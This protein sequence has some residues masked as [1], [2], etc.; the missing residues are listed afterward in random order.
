MAVVMVLAR[1]KTIL[2]CRENSPLELRASTR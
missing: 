1:I 2:T